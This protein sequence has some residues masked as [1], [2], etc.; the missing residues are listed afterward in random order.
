VDGVSRALAAAGRLD[1]AITQAHF[2]FGADRAA[3]SE[4]RDVAGANRAAAIE[5]RAQQGWLSTGVT[6]A[7]ELGSAW[8]KDIPVAGPVISVISDGVKGGIGV[9]VTPDAVPTSAVPD[10]LSDLRDQ[11]AAG[12][13][14]ARDLLLAEA[15]DLAGRYGEQ[16]RPAVLDRPPGTSPSADSVAQDGLAASVE[17]VYREYGSPTAQFLY[18]DARQAAFTGEWA[19]RGAPTESAWT[20][21]DQLY[22]GSAAA[23][24]PH[25]R[26]RTP[27]PRLLVDPG[28]DPV[29]DRRGGR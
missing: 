27:D 21:G 13:R 8:L 9:G 28:Y 25:L 22:Y 15:A 29:S 3:E 11:D 2:E 23:P 7:K 26:S 17:R 16:D 10:L 20:R 14:L 24:D 5:S 4:P 6:V 19:G 12:N 1:G 18:G